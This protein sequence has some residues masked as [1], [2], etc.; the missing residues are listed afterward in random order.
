[1][2]NFRN[3]F[4]LYLRF[5][6]GIISASIRINL[7]CPVFVCK[8]CSLLFLFHYYYLVISNGLGKD[9][10]NFFW[11]SHLNLCPLI[12]ALTCSIFN[13]FFIL[14]DTHDNIHSLLKI[15]FN[16]FIADGQKIFDAYFS[17]VYLLHADYYTLVLSYVKN[18]N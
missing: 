3:L 12:E 8:N 17:K 6:F 14:I 15:D 1:M 10:I 7:R 18:K 9:F 16:R 2:S 13:I 5:L 11:N 4:Y